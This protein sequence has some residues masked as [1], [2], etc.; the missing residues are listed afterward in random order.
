MWGCLTPITTCY[1]G[2]G[3]GAHV[4]SLSYVTLLVMG[5]EFWGSKPSHAQAITGALSGHVLSSEGTPLQGVVVTVTGPALQGPRTLASNHDGEFLFPALPAG[6][7]SLEL[8][9]I[10]YAPRRVSGAAVVLGGTTALGELRLTPETVE[11]PEIEVSAVRPLVDP[12]TTANVTVLDSSRF[13]SLPTDRSFRALLPLVPEADPSPYGDGTNVA[14]ATGLENGYFVDGINITDPLLGDGGLDLPYN[15]VREVQVVT[16]GYDAEYGRTQGGLMNVITN[17][18]GDQ[19]HGQVL[20]FYTGSGLRATP[21]WGVG[22]SRVERFS[23]YDVGA[24]LGGPI[25][26]HRLWL[27][28]AYNPSFENSD[29][30]VPGIPT[31]KDSRTTHLFASNVTARLGSGT[32]LAL[33]LL[34]DPSVRDLVSSVST[35]TAA[36]PGAVLGRLRQGGTAVALQL[37]HQVTDGVLLT[38]SA[39]R[40]ERNLDQTPRA[41]PLTDV[42]SL[43]QVVDNINNVTSGNYGTSYTTHMLRTA[44]QVGLTVLA[45]SHTVKLGAEYE[46]NA[47]RLDFY[48]SQLTISGRHDTTTNTLDTTYTSYRQQWNEN[49][50]NDVPAIYLED[51][52]VLNHRLRFNL[53]L[54]WEGQFMVGDTGVARWIA[55]EWAPRVGV[56]LQPGNLGT[57]KVYAFYGRFFEEIP[58][59]APGLW[60]GRFTQTSTTYPQN[61]LVDTTGGR[62]EAASQVGEAPDKSI[63]GQQYD[64]V[65]V[66]YERRLGHVYRIELRG[67]YRYLRWAVEDAARDTD[68]PFTTGN[69]GRGA[70]AY[71]PRATRN[72]TALQLTVE[73]GGSGPLTFLGSY[74]LSRNWGNYTGLNATDAGVSNSNAGPQFDYPFLLVN[75]TGP[76]P[77]DR[78]HVFKLSGSY[79]FPIGLTVGTSTIVATGEPLSEYGTGFN[80]YWTFVQ[81]RGSSGRTPTTWDV[82]L[83]FAYDVRVRSGSR[84]KP[85]VLLDVFNLGNQRKPLTYDQRHYLSPDQDSPNPNY[86]AVTQYQAPLHA[87]LGMVVDF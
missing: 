11:L 15:F 18:G 32:D 60:T 14:G 43:T 75:G 84:L 70:L 76:L 40:L 82:D 30:T 36:D 13:L 45:G 49:A 38:V 6:T 66:G 33:T 52:W 19:F 12:T 39:A 73:R 65:S 86:L 21:R 35:P 54:R 57:Q 62:T 55:P 29:A 1:W 56:V 27:Y 46:D 47:I 34:G 16:G 42:A 41:G 81:P 77:N 24:S 72:Y 26:P 22:Q 83:R 10:G 71:L 7:Y 78:T 68:S 48:Q 85:R 64:E 50:H 80:G 4:K 31:Q 5:L 3:L 69:P 20:G 61:P 25:L 9:Q 28:A 67:T 79:R 17:T 63:K 23:Q 51:S 8:R 59:A 58:M 74:V 2:S 44:A 53:G 37:H 87:R